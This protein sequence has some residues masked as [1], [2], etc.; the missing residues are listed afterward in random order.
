MSDAIQ[1]R[2]IR[3]WKELFVIASLLV[4]S[5]YGVAQAVR[6][7]AVIE[8]EETE[9]FTSESRQETKCSASLVSSCSS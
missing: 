4:W 6:T 3:P 7:G 2:P 8:T 1:A 5:L 9:C